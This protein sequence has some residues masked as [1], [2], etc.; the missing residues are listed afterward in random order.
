MA[1]MKRGHTNDA[2]GERWQLLT[3]PD[4]LWAR[5]FGG[6]IPAHRALV[7]EMLLSARDLN[8]AARRDGFQL[9]VVGLPYKIGKYNE[10]H[11]Y[12]FMEQAGSEGGAFV[13]LS[14][15]PVWQEQ[16]ATLFMQGKDPH[17]SRAG[18][19]MIAEL[20]SEYIREHDSRYIGS[21]F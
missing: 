11:L 16:E 13:Y 14:V 17:T 19:R 9:L 10:A 4:R 20:L 15:L 2:G 12:S 5:G 7:I 8:E 21:T 3:P 6:T 18:Y 1:M